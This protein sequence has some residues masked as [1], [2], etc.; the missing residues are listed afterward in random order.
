[1]A[2]AALLNFPQSSEEMSMWSFAHQAHHT[3]I[4][5]RISETKSQ[6]LTSYMLD[7]FDPSNM[8]PWLENHSQMHQEMDKALNIEGFDLT[9]LDWN[10]PLNVV[11]WL[12]KHFVEHAIVAQQLGIG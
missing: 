12:Q 3:D 6:N 1:M 5:R 9:E 2:L 11:D 8:A 7:P 10:D 4:L